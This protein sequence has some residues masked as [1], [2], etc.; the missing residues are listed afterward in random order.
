VPL[1]KITRITD[2]HQRHERTAP[3]E[4]PLVALLQIIENNNDIEIEGEK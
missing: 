4:L 1:N 2:A 3:K